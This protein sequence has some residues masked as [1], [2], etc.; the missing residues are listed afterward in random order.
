MEAPVRCM[1]ERGRKANN[2][3][4]WPEFRLIELF[5]PIGLVLFFLA[6][7]VESLIQPIKHRIDFY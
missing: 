1:G 7:L 6:L 2:Q 5:I 4:L 3:K